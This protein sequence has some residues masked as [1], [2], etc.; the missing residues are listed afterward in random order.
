MEKSSVHLNM[1]FLP[2]NQKSKII[3]PCK[4]AKKMGASSSN[5]I[6]P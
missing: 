3:E 1:T 2:N 5:S 4:R 6:I